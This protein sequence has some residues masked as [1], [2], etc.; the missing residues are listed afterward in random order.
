MATRKSQPSQPTIKSQNNTNGQ[1]NTGSNNDEIEDEIQTPQAPNVE[2]N[3]VKQTIEVV[4]Q[5]PVAAP[6]K[7]TTFAKP[8]FMLKG[9]QSGG[10]TSAAGSIAGNEGGAGSGMV[11]GT[12]DTKTAI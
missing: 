1:N 2:S 8:A 6:I 12:Q 11:Y 7:P 10:N 4:Q 3:R 9:R 5:P